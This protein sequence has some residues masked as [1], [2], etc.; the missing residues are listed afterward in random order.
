MF[1]YY[2]IKK[3][4]AGIISPRLEQV[5]ALNKELAFYSLSAFDCSHSLSELVPPNALIPPNF[6]PPYSREDYTLKY[7]LNF[8]KD[9]KLIQRR[10]EM[11]SYLDLKGCPRLYLLE[12]LKCLLWNHDLFLQGDSGGRRTDPNPFF[13]HLFFNS[14]NPRFPG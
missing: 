11:E 10:L 3:W 2:I 6:I 9:Q 13:F 5:E 7:V 8:M 1:F 14:I 4:F 12:R